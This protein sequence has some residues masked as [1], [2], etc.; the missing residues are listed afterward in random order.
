MHPTPFS[1]AIDSANGWRSI[2]V[3]GRNIEIAQTYEP[4]APNGLYL[5]PQAN[6]ATALR[7]RAGGNAADSATGT[8]ARRV[9]LYGLNA[10]GFEILEVLETAGAAQSLETENAFIRLFRA[11]VVLS[12]TYATQSLGSHAGDILIESSAGELWTTIP[13][14]GFPEAITRIGAFTVPIN[15]EAYLIDFRINAQALKL[16]DAVVFSRRNVLETTVPYSPITQL[17]ELFNVSGFIDQSY[18]A[19]IYLPPLTDVG[20]MALIDNQTARV[21]SELGLLLR[22]IR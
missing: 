12:G 11:Q 5:T 16:V 20:V 22:R 4:V 1:I 7:I 19:P 8:G 13:V 9:E 21:N 10:A 14:N 2:K 15:Y 17:I 3:P 18:D 6:A